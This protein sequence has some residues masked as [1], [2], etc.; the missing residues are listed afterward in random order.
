[1]AASAPSSI[2]LRAAVAIIVG[3][4]VCIA[5]TMWLGIA[6]GLVAGW[7]ALALT[8]SVWLAILI[9]PMDAATT[10]AHA[11]TEDP[12]RPV[13]RIVA[14]VGSIVSLGAVGIVLIETGRSPEL[15]S[16]ALAVIAV[17][18]VA[19]SW[20]IIQIDYTLRLAHIYYSEPVGGIGFNQEEDPCYTDF[21]YVALSVGTGYQ[22]GDTTVRTNQ[23]RRIVIGQTLLAYLFGAVIIGTVVNLVIDLG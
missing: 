5:V 4:A 16:Y 14:V 11:V 10:R 1:M 17:L 7:G 6:A 19:A 21:A 2:A 12:G 15:E 8:A 18:S 13:A 3:V 20:M 9:W 23:L 22:V